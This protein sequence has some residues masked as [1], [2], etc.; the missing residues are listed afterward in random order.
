MKQNIFLV[1][2]LFFFFSRYYSQ[3]HYNYKA[4]Y[5]LSFK[6]DSLSDS[7][8]EEQLVLLMNDN[9]ESFFQEYKNYKRDSINSLE[10]IGVGSFIK[11]IKITNNKTQKI[12]SLQNESVF[13]QEDILK[14]WIVLPE[15]S[16]V[17]NVICRN[18]DITAFERRWRACFSEAYPFHFGPYMFSGLPGLI[19]SV[20]DD[21]GFYKFS[22]LS[23]KKENNTIAIPYTGAREVTKKQY[24][25]I[26]YDEAYSGNVFNTFRIENAEEQARLKKMFLDRVK[27]LNTIPIDKTMQYIYHRR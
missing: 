14:N 8:Q 11:D 2:L 20:E 12:T 17:V 19:V 13:Y 25:Q 5:K 27:N 26:E 18:A 3:N 4:I 15:T 21:R 22:L 23:I 10:I 1:F 9:N 24:F 6:T 16:K 7:F